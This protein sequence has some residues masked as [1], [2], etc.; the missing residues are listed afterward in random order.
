MSAYNPP[1]EDLIIFNNAVFEENVSQ[2]GGLT[3][4]LALT[5]ADYASVTFPIGSTSSL[6]LAEPLFITSAGNWLVTGN[7]Q[8]TSASAVAFIENDGTS[9]VIWDNTLPHSAVSSQFHQTDNGATN[10]SY[11]YT[12]TIS[13]VISFAVGLT[14]PI[15]LTAQVSVVSTTEDLTG[16]GKVSAIQ[17]NQL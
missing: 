15:T 2:G 5:T 13:E 4:S 9:F 17:I 7:Y 3:T 1:T 8:F 16:S 6:A 14:Y 10:N 12:H 11:T